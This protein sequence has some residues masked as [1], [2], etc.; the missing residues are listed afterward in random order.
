[1]ARVHLPRSMAEVSF[2]SPL[3]VLPLTV[4]EGSGIGR[5][6]HKWLRLIHHDQRCSGEFQTPLAILSFNEGGVVRYSV[7]CEMGPPP[8]MLTTMSQFP[9]AT[10]TPLTHATGPVL[11]GCSLALLGFVPI[12]HF[13]TL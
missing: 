7:A 3:V 5:A 8:F 10:C 13:L 1:M 9:S 12:D 11:I 6:T 4:G 2:R